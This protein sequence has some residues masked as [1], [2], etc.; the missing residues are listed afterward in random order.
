MKKYVLL[1]S[2]CMIS[3]ISD[4][5]N[6]YNNLYDYQHTLEFN[7]ELIKLNNG[8]VLALANLR[9]STENYVPA[10]ILIREISAESG[11]LIN[12]IFVVRDSLSLYFQGTINCHLVNDSIIAVTGT[13]Q[14]KEEGYLTKG[15][16]FFLKFDFK[17]EKELTFKLFNRKIGGLLHNSLLHTD[18]YFYAVGYE[19]RGST[20]YTDALFIKFDVSGHI[21]WEKVLNNAERESISEVESYGENLILTGGQYDSSTG[22]I[23]YVAKCDSNGNLLKQHF[24]H[25]PGATGTAEVEISDSIIIYSSV[26]KLNETTNNNESQILMRYNADL[27]VVWDTLIPITNTFDIN[28]RKLS[29]IDNQIISLSAI[30]EAAHFTNNRVWSYASSWDLSGN[31]NWEHPFYYDSTFIHHVDD[32]L[33][34]KPNEL[35]FLGT[36][37][38]FG[39]TAADYNQHLWLFN[40]DS[41]GCTSYGSSC[42]ANLND[43][44]PTPP[45]F[46][47]AGLDWATCIQGTGKQELGAWEVASGGTPPFEYLWTTDHPTFVARYYLEDTKTAK[48]KLMDS[49]DWIAP[50]DTPVNFILTVTDAVGVTCVDTVSYLGVVPHTDWLT[51]FPYP[52]EACRISPGDS[53]LLTTTSYPITE[54]AIYDWGVLGLFEFNSNNPYTT[55][56]PTVTLESS[57]GFEGFITDEKGCVNRTTTYVVVTDVE[58]Y[59]YELNFYPNP[60]KSGEQLT[61]EL[62]A[63]VSQASFKMY[64]NAGQIVAD[65]T[66]SSSTVSFVVENISPGMYYFYVS[67]KN[68]TIK[69]GKLMIK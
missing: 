2:C 17:N 30:R 58:D 51:V 23:R 43:Y 56:C 28:L 47:N 60:I 40:T 68:K 42:F 38:D 37:F 15:T 5:H 32:V 6:F 25:V 66:I 52:G 41:V 46:A 69:T 50:V 14:Y 44:F 19:Y 16:P 54:T 59:S 57:L 4:A 8:N 21:I 22:S 27:E 63:N 55:C 24:N 39:E 13:A 53:C 49:K 9:L 33:S 29:I 3:F 10:G 34:I 64:N 18:G 1:F 26:A 48:P 20:L 67:T 65:R 7:R 61:I 35:L 31:F 45:C 11:N 62:P 36:V 12:E